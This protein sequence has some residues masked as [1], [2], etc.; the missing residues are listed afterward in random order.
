MDKNPFLII[1][2]FSIILTDSIY[3]NLDLNS[4]KNR[5]NEIFQLKNLKI[6]LILTFDSIKFLPSDFKFSN[7][8]LDLNLDKFQ[9]D[10][11]Q[12][13]V[14]LENK[15]QNQ[16]Q[17]Q[18]QISKLNKL[19]YLVFTS[20]TTGIP[21]L[22]PISNLNL[23]SFLSNYHKRFQRKLQTRVLQFASHAFDVSVMSIWDTWIHGATI[24]ITSSENLKSDLM[25]SIIDLDCNALDLTPSVAQLLLDHQLFTSTNGLPIQK[26]R[27]IWDMAGLHLTHL[28]TGAESVPESLR[29]AFLSR[30]VSVCVDYGPSETTVGVISSLALNDNPNLSLD[31]IGR[32][33]GLN[34]V[35]LLKPN[36]N[37]FV[38][39]GG[40][41]E[42]CIAGHQVAMGYLNQ[43]TSQSNFVTLQL[44]DLPHPLRIYR[45]GDLGQ[46]LPYGS[47]GYGSIRCLGR[48]DRQIKISG[49]RIE[50]G[51]V[52]EKLN[53]LG[54]QIQ[55]L[56]DNRLRI[57]VDKW[58]GNLHHPIGLV[59][60]VHIIHPSQ[61]LDKTQVL[62]TSSN[63][64]LNSN[65]TPSSILNHPQYFDNLVSEIK[66]AVSNDLIGT[67]LP[68]YWIPLQQI[69]ISFTGKTDMK[70]LRMLLE[71]HFKS[72][73]NRLQTNQHDHLKLE[74]CEEL[75]TQAWLA[76]LGQNIDSLRKFNPTDN[77]IKL[78]GDSI[79]M[80]RAIGK[81]RMNGLNIRFS[82]LAET[83]DFKDFV[84]TLQRARKLQQENHEYLP[85]DLIKR[86]QEEF[87]DY[88]IK[89]HSIHPHDIADIYP[90]CP[91]QDGIITPSIE[92]CSGIY[93]AQAVYTMETGF[94]I[95]LVK[96][97]MFTLIDRHPSLRTIFF[98]P[99]HSNKVYQAVLKH[100]SDLVI[101]NCQVINVTDQKDLQEKIQSYLQFDRQKNKFQWGKLC[102]SIR[103]F[104]CESSQIKKL[105][106]SL[107][108][109]LSDGWTL[110]LLMKELGQL[111]RYETVSSPVTNYAEFVK[112][113]QKASDDQTKKSN[114]KFWRD[115]LFEV[116]RRP[117]GFL[118]NHCQTRRWVGQKKL[119]DLKGNYGI[120]P[121]LVVRLAVA[122][123]LYNSKLE[124]SD[125][126]FGMTRS[127]REV[128]LDGIRGAAEEIIGC[129]VLVLPIRTRLE[130][131]RAKKMS[132]IEV[133][134]EQQ[135]SEIEIEKHQMVSI[136]QVGRWVTGFG[137]WINILVTLQ[138]WDKNRHQVR[139]PI[140]QPPDQ[141]EMPSPYKLSIEIIM[142]EDLE[143]VRLD[144]F[145][146]TSAV[147]FTQ[148]SCLLDALQVAM[149][150]LIHTE[151][152]IEENLIEKWDEIQ[153]NDS[154]VDEI[155]IRNDQRSRYK[156]KWTR[157][158]KEMIEKMKRIWCE[159]LGQEIE[160]IGLNKSFERLGGDSIGLMRLMRKIEENFLNK[161]D[162]GKDNTEEQ[163]MKKRTKKLKIFKELTQNGIGIE[164]LVDE[165][166]N[167]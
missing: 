18:N 79:G 158:K 59:A 57:I 22:I 151:R 95:S 92:N 98:F 12:N 25:T 144:V 161:D 77:F 148:V 94:S 36:S 128:E 152:L 7:L 162:I 117:T 53:R 9:N 39:L 141:L 166:K 91:S 143:T 49:I 73:D 107:H 130:I 153:E 14:H 78:G 127:G 99:N 66:S 74:R 23:L 15:N 37:H 35:F 106:W 105:V 46:Y 3:F 1:I 113:W 149:N 70:A 45:T 104:Q 90:T 150:G 40:I 33:T 93:F 34:Q 111:C 145:Y 129:C 17:N 21:K 28:N 20:G 167:Q 50:L 83:R 68:R 11:V 160:R 103:I 137:Q 19:V 60:F 116:K 156:E 85:F 102:S 42:I 84:I 123:A 72:M 48:I 138:S 6:S 157:S 132:V 64:N 27:K 100:S 139:Q 118:T 30:G 133:L 41:G 62:I 38:P 4:P 44:H 109:A 75:A 29:R 134:V 135:Q 120:T 55:S 164:G 47:E 76:G 88:L 58:N 8:I 24:C 155:V 154:P 67:M 54:S 69:P 2:L 81:I 86:D 13:Q 43:T 16:N 125:V 112:A 10:L 71:N 5:L 56:N 108:H 26:V 32:P 110:E 114:K 52:E 119:E 136:G 97:M 122:L 146:D 65:S 82:T 131:Y 101:R 87:L 147:E 63:T 124:S 31:D 163:E 51:D 140:R 96:K 165:L 121:A 80:I 89:S 115:Y 142:E 126:L 159:V 61:L